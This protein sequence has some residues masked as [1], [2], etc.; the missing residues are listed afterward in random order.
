MADEEQR[1]ILKNGARVWNRWREQNPDAKLSLIGVDLREAV[2]DRVDLSGAMISGANLNMAHL[3]GSNLQRATLIGAD[4]RKADLF[5]ADLSESDLSGADLSSANLQ[6][7]NLSKTTLAGANLRDASLMSAN[8]HGAD[9]RGAKLCRADLTAADL[10]ETEI[11]R[12]DFSEANLS[13][14]SFRGANL[15]WTNLRGA[16]FANTILD[17]TVLAAIDLRGVGGL[18]TVR[19]T[20]PTTVGI[21]TIYLSGG[22]IPERFLREAGVPHQFVTYMK[23][24]VINPIEY[25]SCFISYSSKDE[26]FA[27][28]LHR[29]LQAKFVRCWFAPEDLK[30]GDKFRVKIDEAVRIYDKLLLVLSENSIESPW[31]EE[32][33]EAALEKERHHQK[34]VLFPVR[35][36]DAVMTAPQPWAARVRRILHMGDFRDW[37]NHD[38]YK[39]TFGR[40][41]RDL[42]A[43]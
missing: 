18:E 29:D 36:D 40:L 31:V 19:H 3:C 26:E 7:A 4:F 35:L 9:L 1:E 32:E 6:E 28:L 38:K 23:S 30:I 34:R 13:G 5:G 2:L 33:V 10:S 22:E 14:A 37:K 15:T 11:L 41:L 27:E 39:E 25:Y 20:G 42:R 12:T 43:S 21:D 8:L 16:S 17:R 24:L